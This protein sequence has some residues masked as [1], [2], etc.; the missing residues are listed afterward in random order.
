MTARPMG[1]CLPVAITN[2]LEF[3]V[4]SVYMTVFF[5]WMWFVGNNAINDSTKNYNKTKYDET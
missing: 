3:I 1:L 5:I 4:L 2:K